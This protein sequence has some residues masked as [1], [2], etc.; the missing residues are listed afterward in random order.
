MTP[1]ERLAKLLETAD[2]NRGDFA[3]V[4]MGQVGMGKSPVHFKRL[5]IDTE[6]A[7]KLAGRGA[8]I[9]WMYYGI[10]TYYTQ[11]LIAGA[12]LSGDYDTISIVT[13]SQYGKSW[14][15]G[16]LGLLMAYTGMTVNVVAS[17]ADRTGV[18]MSY[19]ARSISDAVPE[20]KRALTGDTLRKVDR[21]DQS[22][23]KTNISFAEGGK[24]TAFT[25]GDTYG[26]LSHNK[27]IG[28]GG[29]YIVDEA[30]LV[31]EDALSE[32]GRR[33][34]STTD[35]SREP[36]IMIS[37]PHNPG[38]F[39]DQ[40]TTETPTERE[41]IIWADILTA[42]Q[43]GRW[44]ADHAKT[45]TFA[46]HTDT[47]ERYLLCELPGSGA[48]MFGDVIVKNEGT[49]I[50]VMGVDA[51][52]KG[53]DSIMVCDTVLTPKGVYF[54]A[55][56][57]IKKP[58]WIDGVTSEEIAEQIARIYHSLGAAL[59]CCDIGFGVWLVEGLARRGVNVRGVNFG[60]GPTK[61]RI[62]A[63]HYSASNAQNKRAE[64]HLDLQDLIDHQK[65]WFSSTVFEQIKETLPYVTSERKATGKIAVRPKIEIKN[66][67]GHSP[68]AFDAVLLGLH[69]AVM[70]SEEDTSFIT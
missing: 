37:N 59:L 54:E 3:R 49:G 1:T 6:K 46:K 67:I 20:M 55:V 47:L 15:I 50:H 36:L 24:V 64:M 29:A 7:D 16:H 11:A 8:A 22:L 28:R 70:Y 18:I 27:A 44:T 26:D 43:E 63:K 68:D 48:G 38:A 25:L 57:A 33:E 65:C 58:I 21:L 60:A 39:Y 66:L 12:A 41:L 56:E 35:G 10:R 19:V 62:K 30:A 40:I 51:A 5:T 69:A 52:Y 17:T 2:Q 61:E 31:S 14:L 23:S 9:L 34:Y 45:S 42:C 53:K 4:E 32:I 13:P